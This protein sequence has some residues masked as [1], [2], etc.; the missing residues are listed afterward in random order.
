MAIPFVDLKTQ[1]Q[2]IK[3]EVDPAVLKV[4]ENCNF[5]LGQQVKDFENAFANY[6]EA[7]YAVGVDSGYSA[8]ELALR[9]Y[10]IGKGDEVILQAN[11]FQATALAVHNTGAK[12]VLVDCDPDTYNI[13]TNQIEAAITPATRAIMPV[14]LYG[15]PAD[16]GPIME[17]AEKHDLVVIE[18]S[19]QGHGARYNGKRVGGIGHAA[20]FS[21]Y[22]GKNLGAYGDG[23]AVVTNDPAINEKI[24][25]LRNLGMKIKY[26]HDI[27]GY[28]NRLDTMQAA[29][30]CVKLP[31][32]DR[33][34]EGRRQAAAW[35]EELLADTAV[36]TPKTADNVEH[37]FHLYVI[38]VPSKR[39]AFMDY[40]G[41]NGI[42]SGLHYPIPIHCQPSF[43]ELGYSQGDFP[44]TEA[45][46]EQIVSLP[47]F[48]ELT[49]DD[50]EFVAEHIKKF[51]DANW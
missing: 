25:M 26:H 7:D 28:N 8:L 38:R 9:A 30:L 40:L 48:G 42:A 43:S 20:G 32:L 51:S 33:W 2:S 36:V 16:M 21:F 12:P 3:E 24:L 44:V 17:I 46:A 4:M 22:P 11:T 6:C 35:Y 27:K 49:R 23:G 14:H 19:A 34:N 31:Y 45:Y 37:V 47:M 39:E 10:G 1:Y 5:V 18:D 15:Q 41:E 50:V 13:D 29:V